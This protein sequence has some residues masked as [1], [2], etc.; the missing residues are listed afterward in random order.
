MKKVPLPFLYKSRQVIRYN[1]SY[2]PNV[3]FPFL[4]E[5]DG[6]VQIGDIA[7]KLP[8]KRSDYILRV[9]HIW[10]K[11]S[12]GILIQ[13]KLLKTEDFPW[14]KNVIYYFCKYPEAQFHPGNM[15]VY[16]IK[17]NICLEYLQ[18]EEVRLTMTVSTT[19]RRKSWLI[20]KLS[21]L[22]NA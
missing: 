17:T 18:E 5:L 16:L 11:L 6:Q 20:Q 19:Q 2:N 3:R 4:K 1:D 21:T 15:G 22:R 7:E 12:N 13:A 10:A 14:W 9:D 8:E